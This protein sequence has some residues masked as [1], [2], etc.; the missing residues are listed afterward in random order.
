MRF[1]ILRKAALVPLRVAR[2]LSTAA[3]EQPPAPDHGAL[4]AAITERFAQR[5]PPPQLQ[6]LELVD[7]VRTPQDAERAVAAFREFSRPDR[8][9][10]KPDVSVTLLEACARVGHVDSLLPLLKDCKRNGIFPTEAAMDALQRRCEADGRWDAVEAVFA[11][12]SA[13]GLVSSALAVDSYL[14]AHLARGL[15]RRALRLLEGSRHT[16]LVTAAMYGRLLAACAEN[17]AGPVAKFAWR[18]MLDAGHAPD[19]DACV[20]AARAVS[21]LEDGEAEARR[22]AESAPLPT[23][24]VAKAIAA[25]LPELDTSGWGAA[26]P[27][28]QDASNDASEASGVDAEEGDAQPDA[29]AQPAETTKVSKE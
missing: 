8:P 5:K 25:A 27:A 3:P 26:P 18:H 7:G 16:H 15:H 10:V 14:G 28:G 17:G 24:A 13:L 1:A 29:D 23:D 12:R 19:L 2:R 20:A 4:Y 11:A 9:A 21:T 6:L 22:V